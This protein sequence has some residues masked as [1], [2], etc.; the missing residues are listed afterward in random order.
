MT[1]QDIYAWVQMGLQIVIG[2]GIVVGMS[3][4]F[5]ILRQA[6]E[7]QKV[8]IEAQAGHMKAQSAVLQD[9]ERLNNIMKH[10]LDTVSDPAALQREQAYKERVDRDANALVDETARGFIALIGS[11]LLYIPADERMNLIHAADLPSASKE[12]LK[13]LAEAASYAR[14]P[15]GISVSRITIA[16]GVRV[17][18]SDSLFPPNESQEG[19]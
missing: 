10:V 16:D 12:T 5:G 15:S 9:F 2:G 1:T 19:T 4:Y 14:L 8:T 6:I 7:A 13:N 17:V 18:I 3:R 11:A